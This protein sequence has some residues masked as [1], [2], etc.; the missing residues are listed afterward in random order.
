MYVRRPDLD[1]HAGGLPAVPF[2]PA[3]A[4]AQPE[5]HEGGPVAQGAVSPA[6]TASRLLEARL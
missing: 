4:A 2:V 1:R 5:R 6:V 3:S